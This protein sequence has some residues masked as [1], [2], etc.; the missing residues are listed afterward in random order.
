MEIV[1]IAPDLLWWLAMLAL[2]SFAGIMGGL[3]V[4]HFHGKPIESRQLQTERELADAKKCLAV[5][6]AVYKIHYRLL[7]RRNDL[8]D[9]RMMAM[10][11][12]M[13]TVRPPPN[14]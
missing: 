14:A 8:L 3:V 4:W 13:P 6:A 10:A 2:V 11:R 1:M 12:E 7:A 5:N 9:E